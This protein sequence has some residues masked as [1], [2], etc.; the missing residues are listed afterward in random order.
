MSKDDFRKFIS[1]VN[2]CRSCKEIN[3][4]VGE[5]FCLYPTKYADVTWIYIDS[6]EKDGRLL[7]RINTQYT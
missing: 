3:F 6:I 7:I 4:E 2:N 1:E 5:K